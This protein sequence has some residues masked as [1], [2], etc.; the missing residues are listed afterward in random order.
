MPRIKYSI[1]VMIVFL[2]VFG[3]LYR[4]KPPTPSLTSSIKTETIQISLLEL[5]QT[6]QKM[7]KEAGWD[8][9]KPLFWG[10]Y[11]YD[12]RIAKLQ[13]L[14]ELLKSQGF[15]VYDIRKGARN[16]GSYLLYVYE[17]TIHNPSSL[18]DQNNTLSKIAI[19][20]G[21]EAYDGWEVGKKP[22]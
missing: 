21:I 16:D 9:T 5:Q 1:V 14:S 15:H 6:F 13:Q 3:F 11:F 2:L 17:E 18:F 8:T 10:Y 20:N 7:D 12:H 19:E 22:L 4:Q